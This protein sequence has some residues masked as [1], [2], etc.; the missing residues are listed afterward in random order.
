MSAIPDD[1]QSALAERYTLEGE[2]GRGGMATVYLK[3]HRPAS[4][5]S[6]RRFGAARRC[7]LRS[8]WA[9]R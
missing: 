5:E 2:L 3:K 4:E 8:S 1:L 9:A 7:R 6:H